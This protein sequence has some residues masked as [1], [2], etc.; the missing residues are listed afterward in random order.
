MTTHSTFNTAREL[1]GGQAAIRIDGL[2]YVLRTMENADIITDPR[3]ETDTLTPKKAAELWEAAYVLERES[4][5][6]S[7]SPRTAEV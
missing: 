1:L 5:E 6:R 3:T 4:Y 7:K 2:H